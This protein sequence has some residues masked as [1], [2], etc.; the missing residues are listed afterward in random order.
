[1]TV[2]VIGSHMCPNTLY[3][4]NKLKDAGA[5]IDFQ[6][7][8]G[9]LSSLKTFLGIRERSPLFDRVKEAGKIGLPFMIL[10]DGTETLSL[11]E[12]LEKCR[13]S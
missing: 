7:I 2:T 4:L 9:S 3:S 6:D 11:D 8:S 5:D 13:A 12:A 10:E 1:M